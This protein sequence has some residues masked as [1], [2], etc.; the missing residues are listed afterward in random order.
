MPVN[1]AAL[2]DLRR[3]LPDLIRLGTSSWTYPGWHDLVYHRSYP[4]TGAAARMLEEYAR[5]PLFRTVG[6]DST[7]YRPPS[8]KTLL[9]YDRYL[10]PGFP[11]CSK[12]WDQITVHTHSDA[13][14]PSLGGER[15]P[16]F[17]NAGRFQAEVLDPYLEHF[18]GHI[19]PFIFE[20]QAIRA[21]DRV[22]PQRF[23]DW[24]DVF[25]TK[26]PRIVPYAVE[27]RNPEFLHPAYFAVLRE[28]GVAHVFNSW[29]RM[30]GISEQLELE[31]AI[32]APFI[33]ARALLRQGRTYQTAVRDFEPYDR[34]QEVNPELRN[35]LVRLIETAVDAR[36]PAYLLVNNRAEGSAPQTVAAV[37]E[38]AVARLAQRTTGAD[39]AVSTPVNQTDR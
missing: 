29:T 12:V 32:G 19:G 9:Q 30:P 27:V 8:E 25:F 2:E 1:H 28:H 16:D 7:F 10:P 18:A 37:A 13:R 22:S 3:A 15:N 20:F 33:V 21:E 4:K 14:N 35:D 6:I 31:G 39:T 23:A 36:I 11:C 5:F 38:L 17:L 24:L 34:V 26:V